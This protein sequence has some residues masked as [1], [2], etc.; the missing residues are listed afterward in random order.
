MARDPARVIR[1]SAAPR[2][3][4]IGGGERHHG[5]LGRGIGMKSAP[6]PRERQPFAGIE[7]EM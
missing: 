4:P 7:R 3:P 1:L 2:G 6:L 5:P